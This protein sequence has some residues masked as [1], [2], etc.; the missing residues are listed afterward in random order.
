MYIYG[1]YVLISIYTYINPPVPHCS[2]F[3][4]RLGRSTE[5]V[6]LLARAAAAILGR[7]AQKRYFVALGTSPY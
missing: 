3:V 5:A 7:G 1:M 4:W 2:L 6:S